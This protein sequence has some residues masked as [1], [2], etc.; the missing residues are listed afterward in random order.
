MFCFFPPS[1][2]SPTPRTVAL[3]G[4]MAKCSDPYQVCEDGEEEEGS[5]SQAHS[6][7]RGAVCRAVATIPLPSFFSTH[8]LEPDSSTPDR[9]PKK[10][11]LLLN[12]LVSSSSLWRSYG[13]YFFRLHIA[14]FSRCSCPALSRLHDDLRPRAGSWTMIGQG[15]TCSVSWAWFTL[16][17]I[18]LNSDVL[19][20]SDF[21]PRLIT[22]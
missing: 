9:V 14:S 1:V 2:N 4:T 19:L 8:P 3:T 16:Q 22:L 20:R 10:W 18:M 6:W 13:S 21:F 7:N 12:K 17:A 5:C 11:I 15:H